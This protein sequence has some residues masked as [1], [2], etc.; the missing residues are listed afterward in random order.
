M[1]YDN[2]A[3]LSQK[4]ESQIGEF[5]EAFREL[6]DYNG[7]DKNKKLRLMMDVEQKA[8]PLLEEAHRHLV[9]HELCWQDKDAVNELRSQFAS[10]GMVLK[11]AHNP[12]DTIWNAVSR[13]KVNMDILVP[14]SA[15]LSFSL[16]LDKPYLSRDE[17]LFYIID[18][19]VRREK[20][21]GQPYVAPSSWKGSLRSALRCLDDEKYS[22]DKE[23]MRRLFGN[24]RGTDEQDR[25]RSGRLFFYPAFFD[26]V[27]LEVINPHDRAT[28]AGR[29]P[30]YL[31]CA[32]TGAKGIF[33]L[34]YVPFDRVGLKGEEEERKTMA[35]VSEDLQVVALGLRLM[36][37]VYGFGAKTSSGYGLARDE[38]LEGNITVKFV[39]KTADEPTVQ[40]PKQQNLPRYLEAPNRLEAEFRYEDGS[41]RERSIEEISRLNKSDKQLYEKAKK[42]WERK[43]VKLHEIQQADGTSDESG[44]V[45]AKLERAYFSCRFNSFAE[46]EQHA[47]E[48]ADLLMKG[49]D[50]A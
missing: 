45:A 35:Q 39:A 37:T 4:L 41:F 3:H 7:K 27:G 42:W 47:N 48:F 24:E 33:T 30:I 10:S 12:V 38:S 6:K 15:L 44:A 25:L 40:L 21:F 11:V 31:E 49:E 32:P 5:Q 46:L 16:V 1:N 34:L 19:P 13:P 20:V 28:R 9:Y 14:F 43:G 8:K 29:Q 18:N 2:F 50:E 36:L 17:N 22:D 26:K 23:I